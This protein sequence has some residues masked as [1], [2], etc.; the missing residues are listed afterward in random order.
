MRARNPK[1]YARRSGSADTKRTPA[2]YRSQVAD[3]LS[4]TSWGMR[5]K[6]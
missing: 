1:P 4:G 6:P 2:I 3:T 5:W